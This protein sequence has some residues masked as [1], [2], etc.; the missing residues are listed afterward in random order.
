MNEPRDEELS[1]IYREA[2]APEP[3]QSID[4]AIL[5]ASRRAVGSGPVRG[6]RARRWAVPL[7]LAATVVLTFTLTLMVLEPPTEWNGTPAAKPPPAQAPRTEQPSPAR[8]E[9]AA[10]PHAAGVSQVKAR[11][12]VAEPSAPVTTGAPAADSGEPRASTRAPA[13][14]AGAREQG[15]MSE[16]PA[17]RQDSLKRE[18]Q[19]APAARAS[20]PSSRMESPPAPQGAQASRSGA[21]RPSASEAQERSPESWIEDI[22]RLKAQGKLE[23][24]ERELAEFKRRHPDYRLPE[25]LR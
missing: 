13:G 11:R 6:A 16:V 15:F 25:D 9:P 3:R 21:I 19:R 1:R 10:P 2:D 23:E 7:A 17:V 14:A 22:R 5:A 18:A 8:E 24:A 4:E 20:A 12:D